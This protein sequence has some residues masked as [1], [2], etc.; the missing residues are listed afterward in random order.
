[1]NTMTWEEIQNTNQGTDLNLLV[2]EH[3]MKWIAWKEQRG[4]Y[5]YVIFQ[6]PGEREP[7]MRSKNWQAE[8]K[9]YEQ[10]RYSEINRNKHIVMGLNEWSTDISAAWEVVEELQGSHLYT[11]IRTCADFYEVWIIDHAT[12]KETVTVA[13]PKLPHAICKAALLAVLGEEEA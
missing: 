7:Y 4:E 13:H 1:M 6:R 8:Q 5:T 9:R 10:I 2:A 11:D 12:G 3:V